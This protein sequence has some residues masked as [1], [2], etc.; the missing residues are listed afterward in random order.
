MRSGVI[1]AAVHNS[2]RSNRR[3]KVFSWQDFY[4]PLKRRPTIASAEDIAAKLGGFAA[5]GK[6]KRK[7]IAE[8]KQKTGEKKVKRAKPG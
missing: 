2:Q 3:D 5:L 8:S 6:A 1:A 7:Q 4:A